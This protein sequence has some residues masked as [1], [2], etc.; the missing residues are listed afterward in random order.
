[1]IHFIRRLFEAAGNGDPVAQG[2]IVLAF[3]VLLFGW[4][5]ARA[6]L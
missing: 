3:L 2:M 6:M 4:A 5:I 1:M